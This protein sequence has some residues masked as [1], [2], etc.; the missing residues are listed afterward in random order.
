MERSIDPRI[1]RP[2]VSGRWDRRGL[3]IVVAALGLAGCSDSVGPRECSIPRAQFV[4]GGVDRQ[5][6][7]ALL[8]PQVSLRGD[9]RIAYLSLGDRVIGIEFNG[10]PLAI[11]HKILWWHEAVNLE[12]PGEHLTVT[13]APLTGSSLVFDRGSAAVDSFAVTDLVLSTNT[14]LRDESGTLWPQ[15]ELGARCGPRDGVDLALVSYEEVTFGAWTIAHPETWVVTSNTGYEFLYT[16]YPYGDY[17]QPDNSELLYPLSSGIDTRR[18]PKERVLGIPSESGG[19]AFPLDD[20]DQ[21]ALRFQIVVWAANAELDGE[22]VAVF[23]NS[24]AQGAIAYR[25]EIDGQPLTFEVR[26]GGRF[27]LQTGSSWQFDGTAVSGPLDGRQLE[28]IPEAHVAFWFAWAA[29]HPD[30]ELWEL[31]PGGGPLARAP[32][33]GVRERPHELDWSEAIR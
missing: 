18:K 10:Q 5:G 14:V 19:I 4:Q 22:R 28:R 26:E 3:P 11:P 17:E 32:R 29:F 16:L 31:A 1:T 13:Y 2:A 6:I 27:D 12:V 23:W 30:T 25:A 33:D 15:M 20:F 9:P 21:A 8:N 24:L 7:P